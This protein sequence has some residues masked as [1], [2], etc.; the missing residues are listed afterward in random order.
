MCQTC[1][2][3]PRFINNDKASMQVLR[4]HFRPRPTLISRTLRQA[5]RTA[6]VPKPWLLRHNSQ[7]SGGPAT[8]NKLAKIIQ[9]T[10]RV[11]FETASVDIS[12]LDN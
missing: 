9:D 4:T 12:Q 11:R 7:L 6:V 8:P 10:I 5:S 3:Y 2:V 1:G